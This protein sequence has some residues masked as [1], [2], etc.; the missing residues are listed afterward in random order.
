MACLILNHCY[1][2]EQP[3]IP[4]LF[5]LLIANGLNVNNHNLDKYVKHLVYM[6]KSKK[7]EKHKKWKYNSTLQ[8][9][10]YDP[11]DRNVRIARLIVRNGYNLDK[12]TLC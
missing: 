12:L 4:Y 3:A 10:Y 8:S 1:T 11:L 9:N 2:E 7:P 6:H 5:E